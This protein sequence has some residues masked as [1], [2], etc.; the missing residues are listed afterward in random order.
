MSSEIPLFIIGFALN[1]LA[2]L[3]D[4]YMR[5][6]FRRNCDVLSTLNLW[7][8]GIGLFLTIGDLPR[9]LKENNIPYF[10]F[11]LPFGIA[12]TVWV[13]KSWNDIIYGNY[14]YFY[15]LFFIIVCIIVTLIG[16]YV[17]VFSVTSLLASTQR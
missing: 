1:S 15:W 7:A 11:F 14:R 8:G 16:V 10:W 5:K 17:F 13:M 6:F 9:F 4:N 3:P 2:G 12:V